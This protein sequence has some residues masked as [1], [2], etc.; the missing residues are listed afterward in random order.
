[1]AIA[2]TTIQLKKS[3]VT[4]NV[5]ASLNLGE[6]ALN[7]ADGKL[8]YKNASG[9][10]TYISSGSGATTNSFATINTAGSLILATS[11]TDILSFANSTSIV[12]TSNTTTKTITPHIAGYRS[13]LA[14]FSSPALY[15]NNFG[16]VVQLSGSSVTLPFANSMPSGAKINFYSQGTCTISVADTANEFIYSGVGAVA[17]TTTRSITVYEGETLEL[18]TRG[19][20]EWD[21]TDGTGALKF[22]P[23]SYNRAIVFGDGTVQYTANAGGA[24]SSDTV[25]RNMAQAAY[26]Q[27]NVVTGGLVSAN[28]N[29]A[30]LQ[31][32]MTS[33][34]ANISYTQGV[35]T[36][37]NTNITTANNAAWAAYAAG[38]TNATNI[39]YVNTYAASAYGLANTSLQN[40]APIITTNSTSRVYVS[41]TTVSTSNITGALTVAGGLGVSGNIYM[42]GTSLFVGSIN[43]GA[44]LVANTSLQ[45]GI[46][47]T[48]NTNI[49]SVNTYAAS[50]YGQAN[51]VAGGLVSANANV[52]LLQGAMTSANANVVV[53]FGIELAQNTNITTANNAAW[54]A[55]AAGNTNATNITAVNTFAQSAYNAANSAGSGALVQYAAD[56]ANSASSNTIYTQGVD[57]TQNTNITTANNAAQAAFALANT[58]TTQ[59]TVIQGV[60]TGQNTFMQAAF[61]KA[62]TSLQTTGDQSITGN[63]SISKDL[64]VTGNL[65]V[66]GNNVTV[67]TSSFTVVDSMI[68]LGLGNYT[69][70]VLD[71][72]FAGHYNDGTNAHAGFIRDAGTKEWYVFKN[73]T[74]ELNANNNIDIND[75]S[76]RKANVN[77]DYG[78]GNLIATTASVNGWDVAAVWSTQNTNITAVNT[79][80]ASAYALA[81]TISSGSVDPTARNTANT[82]S[83]NTVYIQ[84]VD[85][86]QNTNIT[87][88]NNAAWAAYAAGNTNATNITYVNTYAQSAY[89]QANVVAGGLVSANANIALL[90]GAMTTANA[91]IAF[92]QSINNTQNT[93]IT[94]VNTYAASA[95]GLA[96]TALQNTASIVTSS[97][98]TVSNN[99]TVLNT[100]SIGTGTG[101]TISG[102]NIISANT[103]NAAISFIFADGTVQTT[104]A[105]ASGSNANTIYLQGALNAAN[106]NIIYLQGVMT[107][108]NT[109][110]A[111][112]NT[113][114]TAINTYAQSAFALANTHTTQISIIQGVDATQNTNITTANNAAWAAYAAG[115]TNATNITA[116]NTYAASAYAQANTDYTTIT[117]TAGTY[118][119]TSYVPVF[120]IA[121]NGRI[122][123]ASSVAISGGGSS[124][125]TISVQGSASANIVAASSNT[126]LNFKAESGVSIV[127]YA[128]N[129]TVSIGILGGIQGVQMDWGLVNDTI[130]AVTFDFGPT[131]T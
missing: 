67:N 16:F 25:A 107:W 73:Y 103:F 68:L 3:G 128:A 96:N 44:A 45:S 74:P 94:A 110:D 86:T 64:T 122:T 66:L 22:Q 124:F 92:L 63:L 32:A 75:A 53:L 72:G 98:L 130:S 1:M 70:D 126:R 51:V 31:G 76:F 85:T 35:D 29:I 19:T 28:A 105:N 120:T 7:Y 91:N 127:P 123:S 62:N 34:N 41:N 69:T 30:L 78:K 100:V 61:N 48:Q 118:G 99:L 109:I 5:P 87:T 104:A 106:A 11:N 12:F 38:N 40:T 102:V 80:A 60:D 114:A 59:I 42:S 2:N 52:A 10:I 90:Q 77:F 112:Q 111:F 17:G 65:V 113:Q 57:T 131:L 93:N 14:P 56:T 95:Y 54:A 4:G 125:G 36:T 101:G 84:G 79:Y 129:N 15:A 55:Y 116:V 6:L 58:H 81:N 88:A 23:K 9:V 37:Q 82:A 21:I 97:N 115:N 18:T 39:T 24:G 13:T 27:A 83:S 117:A 46:N 108:Q 33:A 121:A 119:N 50:A 8:Y 47:T 43:I 89:G 49:T 26:D 71:I 20:T